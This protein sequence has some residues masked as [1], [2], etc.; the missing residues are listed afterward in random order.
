MNFFLLTIVPLTPTTVIGPVVAPAGTV[1]VDRRVVHDGERGSDGAAALREQDLRGVAERRSGDG[2]ARGDRRFARLEVL[3]AG[4]EIPQARPSSL[5]PGR[6]AGRERVEAEV[7][8]VV[9]EVV[10]QVRPQSVVRTT[11]DRI[12]E[13]V[14]IRLAGRVGDLVA[15]LAAPALERVVQAQPVARLVGERVAEVV[16]GIRAEVGVSAGQRLVR[17]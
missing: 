11:V 2:H 7:I 6:L 10:D 13:E 9:H 1:A 3:H 14:R 4:R 8:A 17:R 5:H 15:L 12:A 16:D